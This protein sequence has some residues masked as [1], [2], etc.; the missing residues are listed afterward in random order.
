MEDED[1]KGKNNPEK[2]KELIDVGSKYKLSGKILTQEEIDK[3]VEKNKK[4]K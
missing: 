2:K 3:I 1:K 4:K